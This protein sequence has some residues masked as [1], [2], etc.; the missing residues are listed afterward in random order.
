MAAVLYAGADAVASHQSAAALWGLVRSPPSIVEV[1]V[2]PARRVRIDGIKSHRTR[3][4]EGLDVG[5]CDG[6]P[7][8]SPAR[9]IID[10]A[11]RLGPIGL[12]GLI[13]EA[14]KRDLIDHVS[15]L[16]F[17]RSRAGL[18]GAARVSRLLEAHAFVLTDSELERLFRPIARAAGLPAPQ[19]GAR[20]HG[21][22]V[23]FYWPQLGLVV[24][25]DGLRY[26]RT[27][28]QQTRDRRRDQTL[29]AA[30]LVGLR[31]THWQIAHDR[32]HVTRILRET[33]MRLDAE[34]VRGLPQRPRAAE[35]GSG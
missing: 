31:F 17:A 5:V 19:T 29:T 15:L 13:V 10:M 34:V 6:I 35:A 25:T 2:A 30:G 16:R 26:H 8:T 32:R 18:P 24:E 9:T 20:V 21:W 3:R 28:T 4:L 27:P 14:D 7:V 22:K 1:T 12:E 33:A 11:P 23:D